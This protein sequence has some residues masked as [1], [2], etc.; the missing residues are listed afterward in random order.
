M[1][2]LL[3][4]A[5]VIAGFLVASAL[6]FN[7]FLATSATQARSLKDL[8]RASKEAQSSSLNIT[9]GSVSGPGSADVWVHVDNTGSQPV[10]DFAEMDVIIRYTDSSDNLR[11]TYL[12]YNAAG[13]GPDQW[14]VSATG[15]QPD[16]FN[17]RIWD[18]DETLAIDLQVSPA[19][20]SGA[21]VLVVVGTPRGA[22]DQ[23]PIDS[24]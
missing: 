9:N 3:A 14:T 19:I 4:G 2:V 7:S 6:M 20:K 10:A 11:L 22:S 21:P 16:S 17:P 8:T 15:V 1:G 18:S 24:P 23:S 13:A 5:F 12:V